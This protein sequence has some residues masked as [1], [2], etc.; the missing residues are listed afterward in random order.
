MVDDK[1]FSVQTKKCVG[2]NIFS[3]FPLQLI[4]AVV[5]QELSE[6]VAV[7]QLKILI[8]QLIG[9]IRTAVEGWWWCWCVPDLLIASRH[10][11]GCL[12]KF[13]RLPRQTYG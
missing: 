3:I 9:G 1:R 4:L 6:D 7:V 12:S 8:Q 5:D 2:N 10:L 13:K 11:M